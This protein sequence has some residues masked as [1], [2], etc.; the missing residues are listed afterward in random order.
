[1][2]AIVVA[3]TGSK[4][5]PVLL[6]SIESYVPRDVEIYVLGAPVH[7]YSHQTYWDIN[8]TT[9]FGDAYNKVANWAF[10][11]HDRI[12]LANDDIV[13][14]PTS[15]QYMV[16]DYDMVAKDHKVGYMACKTDFA[17]PAQNIRCYRQ[18]GGVRYAEE[19]MVLYAEAISPIFAMISKE[20]WE[21]FPPINW[22]SDDVQSDDIIKKGYRN[23]ISRSYVHHVGSQ[24]LGEEN[25][26]K[27]YLEAK[28][29][30]EANR[31]ELF[32]KWYEPHGS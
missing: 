25:Y 19:G 3:T 26:T 22:F 27:S 12:I 17:R 6:A 29:W 7:L 1:M 18:P 4:C 24:T 32:K 16:E 5:L 10:Q 28:P 14:T 13:L 9:N 23:F 15:Y 21:D 31:P 20:A 11:K 8:D 30:I 2:T